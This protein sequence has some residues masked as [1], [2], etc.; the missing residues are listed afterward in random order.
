MSTAE[1]NALNRQNEQLAY[2]QDQAQ[3]NATVQRYR[4]ARIQ[5]IRSLRGALAT[6]YAFFAIFLVIALAATLP[7]GASTTSIALRVG[8]ALLAFAFPWV[9]PSLASGISTI[10]AAATEM[11]STRTD[12]YRLAATPPSSSSLSR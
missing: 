7:A 10:G 5:T 11:V 12:P 8:A 1:L 6:L 3:I 9:V 4:R 2:L